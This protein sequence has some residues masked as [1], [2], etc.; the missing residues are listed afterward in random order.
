VRRE[1]AV[2]VLAALL[3][4]C[5]AQGEKPGFV[6]MP[7]MYDSV[8]YDAYDRNLVTRAGQTLLL[9]PEG[10]VPLAGPA[11]PYAPG[12]EEAERA[13][14]ELRN[15][16]E[17]TPAHLARGKQVFE[18]VCAVCHGPGGQGDGPI[19]GRF[20]NPPSLLAARARGLPDGRIV[21]V[22]A[23]GQGIMPPH[24]AQ[25]LPD[26]RWRVVLHLRQLQEGGR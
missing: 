13:G 22:I 18:N 3:P 17:P 19:I 10:T 21:H 11:F 24:S 15:P 9:P 7:G 20:P 8:P 4:G 26:D 6:V 1:A 25:V 23:R 16:L 5:R 2:L 14:R 12:A